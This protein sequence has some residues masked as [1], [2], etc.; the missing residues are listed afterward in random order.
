MSPTNNLAFKFK[1]IVKEYET[2]LSIKKYVPYDAIAPDGSEIRELPRLKS[3]SMAHCT[4]PPRCVS[5]AVYLKSFEEIWFF[6]EGEGEVWLKQ[7][8]N[9]KTF[10]VKPGC[11][12]TIPIGT[13]FQFRNTG[14]KHLRFVCA[15]IPP[16]PGDE[17]VGEVKGPWSARKEAWKTVAEI[18]GKWEE[19]GPEKRVFK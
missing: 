10:A 1:T 19:L 2:D 18:V 8:D 12:I 4:L 7:K 9:E 5:Q 13:H 17:E 16:W 14:S 3:G 15:T 6:I 11:S